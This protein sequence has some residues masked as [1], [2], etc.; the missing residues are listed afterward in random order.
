MPER[1]ARED[2]DSPGA[3]SDY[4]RSKRRR[5]NPPDAHEDLIGK[6]RE[7]LVKL[8]QVDIDDRNAVAARITQA[9]DVNSNHDV[10]GDVR[11]LRVL[12]EKWVERIRAI[13]LELGLE[14]TVPQDEWAEFD[15]FVDPNAVETLWLPPSCPDPDSLALRD[16]MQNEYG[17]ILQ[18]IFGV[19]ELHVDQA[20]AID[21][22]LSGRDVFV[23]QPTG[24]GKSL[25]FQLPAVLESMATTRP[26]KITIVISPLTALIRDQVAA[27]RAQGITA[28]S[29]T[30]E[31]VIS[32]SDLREQLMLD[33]R[34]ADR[35]VDCPV[36]LYVTPERVLR[37]GWFRSVLQE[38]YRHTRL[39]RFVVDE[40]HCVLEWGLEFRPAYLELGLLRQDFP[41]VPMMMLTATATPQT[42]DQICLQLHIE[43]HK[44][45]RSS[46]LRANL[47]I[48]I[49][50]KPR[51]IIRALEEF[52]EEHR[53]ESGIIYRRT[54]KGCEAVA[55]KLRE[56]GL[57]AEAFHAGLSSEEKRAVQLRWM[58]GRIIVVA[59]IAFGLG[60]NKPDVRF[61]VHWDCPASPES[62]AQEIGRAGRDGKP[63]ECLAF[64]R[65][66][67]LFQTLYDDSTHKRSTATAKKQAR[68]IVKLMEQ[69]D[70]IWQ[71]LLIVSGEHLPTPCGRCS[72][73]I[74]RDRLTATDLADLAR[75]AL[76]LLRA[77]FTHRPGDM[78][79]LPLLADLLMRYNNERTRLHARDQH[80]AYGA[81]KL[82]GVTPA[83]V[84]VLL[85]RLVASGAL[86]VV[87]SS[88]RYA[89]D[90]NADHWYLKL[91]PRAP[92]NGYLAPDGTFTFPYFES[93]QMRVK[94]PTVSRPRAPRTRNR[95]RTRTGQVPAATVIR[96]TRVPNRS[97]SDVP[98]D[99]TS[100][101][102][103]SS[104]SP[105]AAP[106]PP[107]NRTRRGKNQTNGTT[108][109]MAPDSN[110]EQS[111]EHS[112]SLSSSRSST[113]SDSDDEPI[114]VMS[115]D[116][117]E[118]DSVTSSE[119]DFS[120]EDALYGFSVRHLT[121]SFDPDR[122]VPTE[123]DANDRESDEDYV[124][125]GQKLSQSLLAFTPVESPRV[126]QI[127]ES[128]SLTGWE[129]GP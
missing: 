4:S 98:F 51:N 43:N 45:V 26:P 33:G 103:M 73:C 41:D 10:G 42:I 13:R 105:D 123:V 65:Y 38:L 121:S 113:I 7:E 99:T 44:L 31:D 95:T 84:E 108:P 19:Q 14:C 100:D 82:A 76:A 118:E 21:A 27:C 72:N 15:D 23:L 64:Y 127:S 80:L 46:L 8:L 34:N 35:G 18:E 67:D 107:R 120:E 11:V 75:D 2:S 106:A 54:R 17:E 87:R 93:T 125:R 6:S 32:V 12:K 1:R 39:A 129:S 116:S 30:H 77:I 86:A 49:E 111:V 52:L 50:H 90:K 37:G 56:K 16:D 94:L 101:D 91:G 109:D 119:S 58:N 68:A 9:E 59:T 79:T 115:D 97:D 128:I 60:I 126:D 88:V 22:A 110:L 57:D 66:S 114:I 62:F 102:P 28:V 69:P 48:K 20:V 78:I 117:D 85:S 112:R 71:A 89:E 55:R 63:A 36:L 96:Q 74:R 24:S 61:V 3:A 92:Q 40:A 70:C 81:A 47:H 5:L 122:P 29:L 25:I 83:L 104:Q 124:D 53:N